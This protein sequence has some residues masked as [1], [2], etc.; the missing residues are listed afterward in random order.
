MVV[1]GDILSS[2]PFG[3]VSTFFKL[4]FI[5]PE[6]LFSSFFFL[7]RHSGYFFWFESILAA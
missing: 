1:L 6:R 3:F 4:A 5:N 7:K 2:H